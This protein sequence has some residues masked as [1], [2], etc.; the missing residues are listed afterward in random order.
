MTS[1]RLVARGFIAFLLCFE[2]LF[3]PL[4]VFE[5]ARDF[6]ARRAGGRAELACQVG[7]LP[8]QGRLLFRLRTA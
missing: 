8:L 1:F 7:A 3:F 4:A 5:L 6:I 2:R